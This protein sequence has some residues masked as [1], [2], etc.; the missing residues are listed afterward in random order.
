MTHVVSTIYLVAAISGAVL[1]ALNIGMALL[2]YTLFLISSVLG[3][4]LAH[5]SNADRSLVYVNIIF[6][7]I[8]IVGIV[9]A[10]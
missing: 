8:N 4:W 9:R 2:G 10:L 7:F 1:V 3:G 5:N 6:G